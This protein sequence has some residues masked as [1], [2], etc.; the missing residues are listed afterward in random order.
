AL[1]GA[2]G[3]RRP[4]MEI[5]PYSRRPE[6]FI[7]GLATFYAT[8]LPRP[9]GSF[10]VLVESHEGRPT[11]IEGHPEHPQSKGKT[12]TFAQAETLNL[13]HPDRSREVLQNSKPSTWAEFDSWAER[14]FADLDSLGS[15]LHFL[16]EDVRS[17][18]LWMLAESF[19]K[20]RWHVFEPLDR[21]NVLLGL[22]L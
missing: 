19:K 9:G 18:A 21:D 7:P 16:V 12:D 10:P 6:E 8:S 2:S 1:A 11:K 4:V 15:R 3:C 13:Y 20:A 22:Q 14:H 17:P 5:L